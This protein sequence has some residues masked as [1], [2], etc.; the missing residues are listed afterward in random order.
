MQHLLTP[1]GSYTGQVK[2]GLRHGTGQFVDNHGVEYNGEWYNDQ[3]HGYGIMTKGPGYYYKGQFVNNDYHGVGTW[4]TP[5]SR[6]VGQIYSG[7][8]H[9]KGLL[10]L[11]DGSRF[12]GNWLSGDMHGRFKVQRPE[13]DFV[14]EEMC[15]EHNIH[16]VTL[17]NRDGTEYTVKFPVHDQSKAVICR[18]KETFALQQREKI[19]EKGEKV[20]CLLT[21][22]GETAVEIYKNNIVYKGEYANNKRHGLGE[23]KQPNGEFIA[24]EFEADRLVALIVD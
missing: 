4:V 11:S 17:F 18:G 5:S 13:N 6:Y 14:E 10:T 1:K 24:A 15:F 3:M 21:G 2:N 16:I 23:I 12:T 8:K 7:K 22:D 20:H 19:N 9:G